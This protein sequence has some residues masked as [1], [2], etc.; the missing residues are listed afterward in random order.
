M[1]YFKVRFDRAGKLWAPPLLAGSLVALLVTGP[2]SAADPAL[3]I[4]LKKGI[5]TQQEY[6]E[7]LKEAEQTAAPPAQDKSVIQKEGASVAT[8]EI[9]PDQD[10]SVDLGRGIKSGYD[11]GVYTRSKDNFRLKI[12]LRTQHRS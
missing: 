7:A 8:K 2:A 1:G 6:D 11:R 5:I 4:L 10:N 12:R 9:T 3:K